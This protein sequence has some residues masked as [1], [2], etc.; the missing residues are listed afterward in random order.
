MKLNRL[1]P[2]IEGTWLDIELR[3]IAFVVSNSDALSRSY[4]TF[5]CP[6][7]KGVQFCAMIDRIELTVTHN[8][9]WIGTSSDLARRE[10]CCF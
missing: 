3:Q 1:A 9:G 10:E 6:V 2:D 7:A 4:T 5:G 8:G